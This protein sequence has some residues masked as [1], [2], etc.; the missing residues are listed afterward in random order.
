VQGAA[1]ANPD[2]LEEG[3]DGINCENVENVDITNVRANLNGEDGI[4]VI[5]AINV[6]LDKVVAV[7]NGAFGFD[8]DST[9][10][11]VVR[12]SIFDAN[13]ISGFEAAGHNYAIT[14][15][16]FTAVLTM[17]NTSARGNGE[18]GI[19][20]ERF[21]TTT[22]NSVTA[23]NNV[24]DGFDVDRINAVSVSKSAFFNNLGDGM[25]LYPVNVTNFPPD[26]MMSIIENFKDLKIFGNRELT[27]NHPENPD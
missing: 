19:E 27:I 13:G 8:T 6:V 23:N 16:T 26:F 5:G 15:I 22:L 10:N 2:T 20:P 1:E 24:D 25:E 11:L 14:D 21:G 9:F 3:G 7:A 12:N 17:I 4:F 18:I